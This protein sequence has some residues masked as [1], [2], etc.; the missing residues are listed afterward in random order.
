MIC[1][2]VCAD[3]AR[4]GGLG[5]LNCPS[6]PGRLCLH[7]LLPQAQSK[8]V[9]GMW[10]GLG[11]GHPGTALPPTYTHRTC[12]YYERVLD[13]GVAGKCCGGVVWV[14]QDR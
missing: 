11:G 3:F 13:E 12:G 14:S 8:M 1:L 2:R 7:S 5:G 4:E 10:E 9:G 6:G